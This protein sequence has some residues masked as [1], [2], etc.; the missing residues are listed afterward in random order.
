M[1]T[2]QKQNQK[3]KESLIG[4]SIWDRECGSGH[5]HPEQSSGAVLPASCSPDWMTEPWGREG[6][7]AAGPGRAW[8]QRAHLQ[9]HKS[10]HVLSGGQITV[11]GES[12]CVAQGQGGVVE[13]LDITWI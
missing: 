7:G 10:V 4:N 13:F 3:F 6:V 5:L 12:C 2:T 1:I 9:P 11:I 8:K